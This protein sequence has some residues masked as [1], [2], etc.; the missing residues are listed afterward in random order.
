MRVRVLLLGS[1]FILLVLSMLPGCAAQGNGIRVTSAVLSGDEENAKLT[2]AETR[3]G[4]LKK[5]LQSA[6][7][8]VVH[9]KT[10]VRISFPL[11]KDLSAGPFSFPNHGKLLKKGDWIIVVIGKFSSAPAVLE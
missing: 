8:S 5:A 2:I 1:A 10:G 4:A 6:K 11:V 9:S 7:L 3:P